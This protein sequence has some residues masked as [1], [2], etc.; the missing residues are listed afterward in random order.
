MDKIKPYAFL[1]LAG[2]LYALGYPSRISESLIITPMIS[3]G[4]LFHY[5]LKTD[6]LKQKIKYLLSFNLIFN[7]VGYY[8]IADTLV[9]FGELPYPVAILLNALFA[10]I[11]TPHFWVA[12][13]GLHFFKGKLQT[14]KNKSFGLFALSLSIALTILEYYTPQQ[15][16]V[17]LGQPLVSISQYL[18]FAHISGLPIYSF[19][20]YLLV[21]EFLNVLEFKRFSKINYFSILIFIL[22]NPI[23]VPKKNEKEIKKVNVRLV[24]ANISNFLKVDSEKGTY[25]STRQVI[26]RYENLSLK[27]TDLTEALDLII[28]PETAYPFS[29]RSNPED[30]KNTA[31]PLAF[32]NVTK[33]SKA[34]LFTGG[35]DSQ[36]TLQ[37][38]AYFKTEHNTAFHIS[39]DGTLNDT[40]NKR[41][42]IPFGETLPF[43]FLNQYLS[44]FI[45]NISF[46]K[47]GEKFTLFSLD[48]GMKFFSTICYELLKPK[49]IREYLNNL[50]ERPHF[51]INL[52]NDSWYGKT[53]EPHQHLF[54]AKWRALEFN[55]PIIRSTNTGIS[56]VVYAD[57]TESKRLGVYKT[58][59]LDL[60]LL[61]GPNKPTIYQSF[62][63]LP[64]FALWILYFIFHLLGIKLKNE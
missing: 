17:F 63:I 30:L 29:L 4:I 10:L 39:K 20:S 2:A 46:F 37:N 1:F 23:L 7:L 9:E 58:G 45:D 5:L 15:F 38:D 12:I 59:N 28:W 16:N 48:N 42:L 43:G 19:F 44:K 54:L 27:E 55:I 33:T 60:E 8:W 35:Y 36:N 32:I 61:F 62:G 26:E 21:F 49:F 31:L 24:Q 11:I 40:Y 34:D 50:K 6:S 3:I 64:L 56:S 53:M 57:G 14:I 52:T 18:G 47:E 41:E 22:L 13:L 25:A 51:M